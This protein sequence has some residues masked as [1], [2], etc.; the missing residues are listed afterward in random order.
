MMQNGQSLNVAM[1]P[2]VGARVPV[3]TVLAE[4][5]GRRRDPPENA[6]YGMPFRPSATTYGRT[7]GTFWETVVSEPLYMRRL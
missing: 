6:T 7:C 4:W 5:N 1:L 2:P 3:Q